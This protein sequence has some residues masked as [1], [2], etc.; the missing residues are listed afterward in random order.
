MN[1]INKIIKNLFVNFF[2]IKIKLVKIGTAI[3]PKCEFSLK[4]NFPKLI[5]LLSQLK[6]SCL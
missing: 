3:N 5:T 6:Y 1:N 2:S 4:K